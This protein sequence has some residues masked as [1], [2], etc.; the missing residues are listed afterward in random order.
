[1]LIS[2]WEG[3]ILIKESFCQFHDGIDWI[4]VCFFKSLDG[5]SLW[6]FSVFHNHLNVVW[7]DSLFWNLFTGCLFYLISS[8]GLLNFLLGS[9]SGNWAS[10]L[11]DLGLTSW[12]SHTVHVWL[13]ENDVGIF[14]S[15]GFPHIWVINADN[16]GLSFFNCNSVDS[17]HG[18]QTHLLH[19]FFEF[20]LSSVGTT[21]FIVIIM[22]MFLMIVVVVTVLS[23]NV[24][25]WLFL[26]SHGL[27][28]I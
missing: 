2:K 22:I 6:T 7:C 20:L 27:D 4:I 21:K 14:W 25:S 16:K 24:L 17:W 1:M 23:V 11:I 13:S 19:G 18:F 26:S 8:G 28:N 10:E 9:F 12:S 15:W 5:F 3:Y